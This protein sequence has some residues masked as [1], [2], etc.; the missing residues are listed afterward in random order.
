MFKKDSQDSL[1]YLSDKTNIEYSLLEGLTNKRFT[2]DIVF[3]FR[4]ATPTE[5]ENDYYGEVIGWV[6]DGFNELEFVESKIKE[7]ESKLDVVFKI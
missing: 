3:I 2:S 6:F 4:E 7:Y 5:M 1:Y